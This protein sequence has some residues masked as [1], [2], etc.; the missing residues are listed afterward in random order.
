MSD[1]SIPEDVVGSS[2]HPQRRAGPNEGVRAPEPDESG[3]V[4]QQS[5]FDGKGNEIVVVTG[6]DEEGNR[7]Q[8]TGWSAEEAMEDAGDTSEPIGHGFGPSPEGSHQ[9]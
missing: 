8:G 1:Q 3:G 6:Q 4:L 2:D 9:V 7:K 5:I